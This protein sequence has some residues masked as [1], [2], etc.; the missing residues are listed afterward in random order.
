MNLLDLAVLT[1]YLPT[2]LH[3]LYITVSIT[4]VVIVAS[5]VLAVPMALARLSNLWILRVFAGFYVEVIRSTP[6]ILQLIYIYF[7]L[8][9]VGIKLEGWTAAVVGLTLHYTAYL[10]E[11]YRAGIQSLPKGQ[12][13][14]AWALG[15]PS[16][17]LFLRIILPQA[18]RNVLP[19]IGNYFISLFKDT[20]LASVVSV[21]EL[22]FA[23]QIIASRT[24][25]YFTIYTACM[26]AYFIVGYGASLLV[27][28][29]E[30]RVARG[31]APLHR[32][33]AAPGGALQAEK[34]AAR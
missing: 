5:L 34:G 1:K 26:L 22:M 10:C 8:P 16:W 19:A 28:R 7:V 6:I 24:Y 23:G 12:W 9:S 20:S 25:Q 30:K 14:A 27:Q 17:R 4:L 3:G 13:E 33:S 21:Q 32:R 2:L 31:Y 15:I 11:V 29:L 18:F